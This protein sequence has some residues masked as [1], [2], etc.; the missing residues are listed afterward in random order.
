MRTFKIFQNVY[1]FLSFLQQKA[2]HFSLERDTKKEEA[3]F[4]TDEGTT[5]VV[6]DHRPAELGDG[7]QVTSQP[8][9]R[10]NRQDASPSP[11]LVVCHVQEKNG[12]RQSTTRDCKALKKLTYKLENLL[13]VFEG[14][15][16]LESSTHNRLCEFRLD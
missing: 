5:M 3:E 12:R 4:L 15:R 13:F 9:T 8:P 14:R 16:S 7:W 10:D 6:T 1:T 11:R 2:I